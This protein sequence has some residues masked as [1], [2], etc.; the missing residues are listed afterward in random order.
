MKYTLS[1]TINLPRSKVIELFDNPDNMSKWQPELQSFEH[2]SGEPGEPGAKSRLKY[3]M[4]K[5]EVEMI[6]TITARN[7]LKSSPVLMR[8]MVF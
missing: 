5:R 7:C 3:K 4:G 6:E 2:I 8:R 1:T